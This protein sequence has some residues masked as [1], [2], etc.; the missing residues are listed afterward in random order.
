MHEVNALLELV[1]GGKTIFGK[2]KLATKN[3]LLPEALRVLAMTWSGTP[4]VDE[5][6]ELAL[7]S[8]DPDIR[9]AVRSGRSGTE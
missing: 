2:S 5:V 8:K 6:L 1:T 3:A 4:E 9:G 7:K